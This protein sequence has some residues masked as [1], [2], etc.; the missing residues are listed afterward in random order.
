MLAEILKIVISVQLLQ[1]GPFYVGCNI[2][3]PWWN[4]GEHSALESFHI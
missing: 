4:G 1:A 2:A 3:Q